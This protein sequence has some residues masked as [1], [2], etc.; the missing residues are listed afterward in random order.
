MTES[1][2]IVIALMEDIHNA[3]KVL[4]ANQEK[5]VL[6]QE[7]AGKAISEAAMLLRNHGL[8]IIELWNKSGLPPLDESE[9]PPMAN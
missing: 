4:T 3:V 6:E 7:R 2:A 5:I 9:T 1:E 8:A